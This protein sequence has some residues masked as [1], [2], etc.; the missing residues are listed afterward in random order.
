MNAAKE[1]KKLLF[2][3][4]ELIVRT[5]SNLMTKIKAEDW[6]YRPAANM[7]SLEELAQ[8]LAGVPSVD[9]EILHEKSEPDI[10]ALEREINEAGRDADKL[11]GWL[12]R[13]T[14]DLKAYMESLSDEDFLNKQTKPFYLD[15]GPVQAKWLIEIVTHAQHHRAQLFNYLKAQGYDINMFDLY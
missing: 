10:R 14:D 11:I 13:G 9:L 1:M 15:H 12:R 3:E 2:E 7:R 5:T 4:L 8:H 6:E